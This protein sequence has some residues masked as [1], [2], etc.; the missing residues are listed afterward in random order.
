MPKSGLKICSYLERYELNVATT[1]NTTW[2]SLVEG[3]ESLY[4][5]NC[6]SNLVIAF[7]ALS[8]LFCIF[9]NTTAYHWADK[10]LHL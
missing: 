8:P 9:T 2:S 3:D 10:S 5:P 4:L 6:Q 1:V 7:D